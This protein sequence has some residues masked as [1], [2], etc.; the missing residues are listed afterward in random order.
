MTKSE[1]DILAEAQS[2]EK[3]I[4]SQAHKY[5]ENSLEDLRVISD[6]MERCKIY[7]NLIKQARLYNDKASALILK[8]K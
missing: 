3:A 4:L 6:R 1:H 8:Y 2:L 5:P 7:E